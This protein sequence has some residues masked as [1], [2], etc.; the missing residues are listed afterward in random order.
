VYEEMAI[1][2][3]LSKPKDTAFDKETYQ[4]LKRFIHLARPVM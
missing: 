1:E 3:V 4:I 2:A